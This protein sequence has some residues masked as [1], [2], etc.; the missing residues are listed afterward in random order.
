MNLTAT[1]A[2]LFA[3]RNGD[4]QTIRR[5]L[6][7]PRQTLNDGELLIAFDPVIKEAIAHGQL[8]VLHTLCDC[9]IRGH[10]EIS[11]KMY[12]EAARNAEE[13]LV[14]SLERNVARGKSLVTLPPLLNPNARCFQLGLTPRRRLAK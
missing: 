11:G 9:I 1:R 5:R 14:E 7:H 8:D 3:A 6:V 13:R 4:L 2:L 10:V 12:I